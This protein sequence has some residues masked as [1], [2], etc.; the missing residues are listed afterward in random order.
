MV[1]RGHEAVHVKNLPGGLM[2]SD[3]DIAAVADADGA[4]VVTKD[5]DFRHAHTAR[6]SPRVV[7]L[8][9]MGNVSNTA[10]FAQLDELLDEVVAAFVGADLVEI[11]RELIVIHGRR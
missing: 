2:A 9:A 3:S 10:M 5:S 1:D 8:I 11:R 6:G 7:L 4:V